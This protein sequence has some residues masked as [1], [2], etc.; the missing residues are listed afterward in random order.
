[1]GPG[2]ELS[3]LHSALEEI[4]RR[5]TAVAEAARAEE[6]QVLAAELFTVERSL[7]GAL[8]RLRRVARSSM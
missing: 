6:N 7:N 2:A 3:A 1:M 4:L 5:V 8:R